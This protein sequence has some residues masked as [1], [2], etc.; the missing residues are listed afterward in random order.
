VQLRHSI[1]DNLAWPG[2]SPHRTR[3]GR[4]QNVSASETVQLTLLE[5]ALAGC[6][7]SVGTELKHADAPKTER[8]D[9]NEREVNSKR[10]QSVEPVRSE[11][12]AANRASP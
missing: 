12:P 11:G 4:S 6:M 1:T 7:N 10:T 8:Q 5:H 3:R 9:T 2:F